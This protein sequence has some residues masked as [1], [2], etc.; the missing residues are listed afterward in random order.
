MLGEESDS[1]EMTSSSIAI[2]TSV[3]CT[4]M[5]IIFERVSA[6][7][8]YNDNVCSVVI[9]II[10]ERSTLFSTMDTVL[11]PITKMQ[12]S[13]E[14]EPLSKNCYPTSTKPVGPFSKDTLN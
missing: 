5:V 6:A 3:T 10:L 8:T 1:V 11:H 9:I 14:V 13:V 12:Y 2:A 4:H 7:Y